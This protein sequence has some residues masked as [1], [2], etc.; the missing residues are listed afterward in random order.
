MLELVVGTDHVSVHVM[1]AGVGTLSNVHETLVIGL[2]R[3][4]I[5]PLTPISRSTPADDEVASP[6]VWEDITGG[7]VRNRLHEGA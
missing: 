6:P 1:D 4:F 5:A 3:D 2:E 7:S